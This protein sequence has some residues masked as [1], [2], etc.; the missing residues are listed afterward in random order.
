MD[1]KDII[2][3]IVFNQPIKR[4]FFIIDPEGHREDFDT[5]SELVDHALSTNLHD[6]FKGI[7]NSLDMSPKLRSDDKAFYDYFSVNL[8]EYAREIGF[9]VAEEL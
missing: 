8:E 7:W 2:K 1:F 4:V 5:W 6:H 9:I 3:P